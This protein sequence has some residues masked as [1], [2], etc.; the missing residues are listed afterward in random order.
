VGI[1]AEAIAEAVSEHQL[2][3]LTREALDQLAS[4]AELL[5]RWNARLNLTSIR[6]DEGV[7][8]RHLIEGIFAASLIPPWAEP[9]EILD[10]GSGAGVPGIPIAI[11]RPHTRVTLAESQGKKAAFLREASRQL[12]L[13]SRTYG[14]RISGPVQAQGFDWV[15]MRAVDRMEEMLSRA[16]VQLRPKG[17]LMLLT[18][19][20]QE[21]RLRATVPLAGFSWNRHELAEGAQRVAIVGQ[22]TPTFDF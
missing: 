16:V 22:Q 3:P 19:A 10:F 12:G 9:L 5:Q 7:L 8:H 21:D 6:T 1:T 4:F 13:T 15:T 17:S 14:E 11:C 18:S 20:R 2:P